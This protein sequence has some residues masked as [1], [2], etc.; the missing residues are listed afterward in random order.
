M[1]WLDK[2]MT[3]CIIFNAGIAVVLLCAVKQQ[4]EKLAEVDSRL[5]K[6]TDDV[7]HVSMVTERTGN[8]V[9]SLNVHKQDVM[10]IEKDVCKLQTEVAILKVREP[11]KSPLPQLKKEKPY[12]KVKY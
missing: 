10:N 1:E 8:T 4:S 9:A 2:I 3:A 7:R 5:R 6:L 11:V 12:V